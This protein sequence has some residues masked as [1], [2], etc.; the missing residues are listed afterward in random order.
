RIMRMVFIG[1]LTALFLCPARA[2]GWNDTGHMTVALIAW[3]QLDKAQ[4][5]RVSAILKSHPHYQLYLAGNHPPGVSDDEWAFLRAATWPDFVRPARPGSNAELFKG[6]EITRYHQG[7]WHYVDI[8][9][10]PPYERKKIDP[11]T[12][13]SRQEPNILT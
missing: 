12:L 7:P 11:T 5:Q 13:P 9:W 8:P 6:P 4:Q 10:V 2:H 1:L 3:R